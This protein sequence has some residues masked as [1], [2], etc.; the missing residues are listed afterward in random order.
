[1]A[2]EAAEIDR[3]GRIMTRMP[4]PPLCKIRHVAPEPTIDDVSAAVARAWRS[5]K[6]ASRVRPG[7]RIAVAVGS[8]GIAGHR[9]L[10]TATLDFLKSLG[11]S[12]FVVAAMGS[13]G[14]G[15]SGGQRQILADFGITEAELGVP[16]RTEMDVVELGTNALG[17]PVWWDQNAFDADGVVCIGRVKPHTDFRGAYESGLVKMMVVGLGKRIGADALHARGVAGLT[18]VMPASAAVVLAKTKFLGG[19]AVVENAHDRPSHLEVVDRDDVLT[20]EP[21]LLK[22]ARERMGRLPFRALDVLVLGEIGKNYSGCGIDPNVVGRYLVESRPDLETGDPA[23]TRIAALDLSPES[24]GNGV[25]CGIADV[26]TDRLL[27]AID[28]AVMRTNVLTARFLWRAKK[29]FGF[30]TDR[31]CI[32][33]AIA[34]CWQ[35]N[36]DELTLAVAPNSLEVGELWVSPAAANLVDPTAWAI[37]PAPRDW[38]FAADGTLDQESLFPHSVR[39]RRRTSSH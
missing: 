28:D 30:P 37:D 15:T 12:P 23:I 16:V 19:L 32:D 31:A 9:T 13:H 29:P 17:R 4:L 6:V 7:M 27:H 34:S 35:P 1:M 14:G 22:L 8:R 38:P 26:V 20:R 11:A 25:G 33:A 10:V 24:H 39:C 3:V 21:E 36:V 18:D 2:N 5:S